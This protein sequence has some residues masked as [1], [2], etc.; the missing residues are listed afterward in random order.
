ME[1]NEYTANIILI[2]AGM[3][4]NYRRND[5]EGI[6]LVRDMILSILPR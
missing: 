6:E 3:M 4:G 2:Y 5:E 1:E